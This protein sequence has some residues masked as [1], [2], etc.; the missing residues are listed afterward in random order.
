ME[1]KFD[2]EVKKSLRVSLS[3]V[4]QVRFRWS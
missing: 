1:I 3:C 4:I 2:P